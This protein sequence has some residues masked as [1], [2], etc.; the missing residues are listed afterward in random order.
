MGLIAPVHLQAKIAMQAI[1]L[2]DTKWD[3]RILPERLPAWKK[4]ITGLEGLE[5]IKIQ[6]WTGIS[7]L[8]PSDL[9]IFCDASELAYGA[10]A[11]EVQGNN[12]AM[13]AAKSRVAPSP[14]RALTIPRLELLSNLLATTLGEYI[15]KQS[16]GERKITIWTDSQ[17]AQAWITAS[18]SNPE[19]WVQNRVV[20][21]KNAGFDTP[22]CEGSLNPADH[23]SRGVK[24]SALVH[25]NWRQGPDWVTEPSRY[26]PTIKGQLPPQLQINEI[27]VNWE[28]KRESSKAENVWWKEYSTK[29]RMVRAMAWLRRAVDSFKDLLNIRGV[30]KKVL[31]E[32]EQ[33]FVM[34][35]GIDSETQYTVIKKLACISQEEYEAADIELVKLSQMESVS[36]SPLSCCHFYLF[37]FNRC[38]SC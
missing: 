3:D 8:A 13:I 16:K 12:I 19:I 23:L 5:G 6:R 21:I 28:R 10:V 31:W 9:H 22:F 27:N 36:V 37:F 1:W 17:I 20:K 33:P 26:Q 4:F 38:I 24:A 14:K 11:Y 35:P 29:H 30:G 34:A 7:H 32:K 18:N 25:R 15:T 2:D